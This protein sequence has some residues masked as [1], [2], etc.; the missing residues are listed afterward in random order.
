MKLKFLER[1]FPK[2]FVGIWLNG[3][4]YFV[5]T[6][7]VTSSGVWSSEN[8]SYNKERD[9]DLLFKLLERLQTETIVT[10]IG[11]LDNSD[12]QGAIPTT[13]ESEYLNYSEIEEYEEFDDIIFHNY[14]DNWSVYSLMSNNLSFQN[15]FKAIGFDYLFSPFFLPI[16]AQKRNKLIQNTAAF[17]IVERNLV[18]FTVFDGERMLYG[19]HITDTDSNEIYIEDSKIEIENENFEV[20]TEEE[21]NR[22]IESRERRKNQTSSDYFEDEMDLGN[23][24][25][26]NDFMPSQDG[27]DAL[28]EEITDIEILNM[29]DDKYRLQEDR[30][31][32]T[33]VD[34]DKSFH[35]DD[36]F[37]EEE[38]SVSVDTDTND[39]NYKFIYQV[40]KKSVNEF[41]N[42]SLYQSDF[43]ES[44]YLISSMHI[45][46]SFIKRVEDELSF[47]TEKIMIEI[48]ELIV[49]LV[50]EEVEHEI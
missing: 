30:S 40:I 27:K 46:T 2:R 31:L 26:L 50:R 5:S 41:Y 22:N 37:L 42:N 21:L 38:E 1:F 15:K 14:R 3:D 13:K 23:L 36:D 24:D 47:P 12:F 11:F 49:E 48:A 32:E 6:Q 29:E 4:T 45:S 43:I 28:E 35:E 8:Y 44:C 33:E 34:F 20:A 19:K 39:I 10:Y 18:I 7:R 9:E 17:V 16:V 25:D